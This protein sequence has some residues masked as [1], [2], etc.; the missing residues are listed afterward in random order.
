SSVIHTVSSAVAL[1][2]LDGRPGFEMICG[3][4]DDSTK[5]FAV[6]GDGTMLPGWPRNPAPGGA[7]PGYWG[8]MA[9]VDVDND[10]LAEIFAPARNGNLYAWHAD[11]SPL[12]ADAAFKTGFGTN[13]RTSP[14]FANLDDQP[15]LEIVFVTP[16]GQLNVWKPDGSS[17]PGFPV[18]A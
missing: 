15:D 8:S 2:D 17:L 11:G 9:A 13:I 7:F 14:A 10:G 1:S 4:W 16:A 5:V 3:A 12:G 6:R 18:Q